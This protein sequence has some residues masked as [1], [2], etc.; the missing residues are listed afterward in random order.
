[1]M[2]RGALESEEDIEDS[3]AIAEMV[4]SAEDACKSREMSITTSTSLMLLCVMVIRKWNDRLK[5]EYTDSSD[6]I[7]RNN[8]N[9]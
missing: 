3:Y 8:T 6:A 9:V 7:G 2:E 1:M 5:C 4:G